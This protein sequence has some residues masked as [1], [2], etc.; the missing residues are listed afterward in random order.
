MSATSQ[1]LVNQKLAFA[2]FLLAQYAQIPASTEARLQKGAVLEG[3]LMHLACAYR[4]YL[5]ELAGNAR[6]KQVNRFATEDAVLEALAEEGR[7]DA[8]VDALREL[9][10][11]DGSW[12]KA[13]LLAQESLW[14]AP[15]PVAIKKAFQESEGI[16]LI[17]VAEVQDD[18]LQSLYQQVSSWSKALET[19]VND[20]RQTFFEC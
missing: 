12:L 19:L 7:F 13:M 16:S 15:A 14:L 8:S 10:A 6:L 3:A 11:A 17:A 18:P 2:R 1:S 20:Y 5:H 9:R 4:H